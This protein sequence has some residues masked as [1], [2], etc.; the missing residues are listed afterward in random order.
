MEAIVL[1]KTSCCPY[2]LATPG[3]TGDTCQV[4]ITGLLLPLIFSFTFSPCLKLR[5]TSSLFQFNDNLGKLRSSPHPSLDAIVYCM[6]VSDQ[7]NL[8]NTNDHS[9]TDST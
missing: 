4:S 3:T 8:R 1:G 2:P 6:S 5:L 9:R 7:Y